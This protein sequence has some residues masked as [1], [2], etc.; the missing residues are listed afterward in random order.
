MDKTFWSSGSRM[1]ELTRGPTIKLSVMDDHKTHPKYA[2][3]APWALGVSNP[4]L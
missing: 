2:A 1:N 4:S 3:L